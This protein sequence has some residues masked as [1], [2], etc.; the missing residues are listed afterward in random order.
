MIRIFPVTGKCFAKNR[1]ERFLH[2]P[3]VVFSQRSNT[4]FL[5]VKADV[6]WFDMPAAQVEFDHRN[7]TLGWIF[8]FGHRKEGF[9]M[10]HEAIG[11]R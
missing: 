3:A 7:E 6:R 8:N 11:H 10:R 9:R 2:A 1:I 4:I 5:P